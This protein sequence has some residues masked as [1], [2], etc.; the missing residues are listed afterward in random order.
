[1]LKKANLSKTQTAKFLL[2]ATFS[3]VY[4]LLPY[5]YPQPANAATFTKVYV[6]TDLIE[7]AAGTGGTICVKPTTNSSSVD[8]KVTWPTGW[9]VSG[10]TGDWAATTTNIPTSI[11][12]TTPT[13]W[14][15]IGAAT[16]AVSGQDVTWTYASTTLAPANI[17]CFRFT[18]TAALTLPAATSGSVNTGTIIT[19]ASGPSTLDSGS[20]GEAIVAS[21]ND[22]VSVSS[23][24]GSTFSFSLGSNSLSLG[25]LP[26]AGTPAT[27]NTTLTVST[28]ATN[29][30]SA[31]IKSANAGLTS[32]T[33]TQTIASTGTYPSTTNISGA[34]GYQLN[35][36][37]GSGS[38]TIAPG[39]LSGATTT[40]GGRLNTFY[41]NLALMTSP[42]SGAVVTLNLLAEASPTR[43][44]ASDYNDTLTV[45]ASGSF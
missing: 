12:G 8:V 43:L 26:T 27:T 38:P 1:M 22:Q 24:V 17:Y 30:W 11:N 40:T 32:S 13:A 34:E 19:E 45:V 44:P 29:G 10:T 41:Q 2:L 31:W 6:F 14:P 36:V 35:A 18:N 3:L 37:S 25:A 9:T 5:I 20:F 7:A 23:S 42:V 4:V 16:V 15:G 33:T 28:N 21:T 39:Y